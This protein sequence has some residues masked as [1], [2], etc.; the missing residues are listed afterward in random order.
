M[1]EEI[2][3]SNKYKFGL[4]TYKTM[5]YCLKYRENA[6]SKNPE[7]GRTENRRIMFLSKSAVSDSKKLKFIEGQEASGLLSSLGIKAPLN[8]FSLL[9][10][11][12]F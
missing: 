7:V 2:K 5:S 6:E 12:L 4:H 11:L 1:K 9:G 10:P 8:K 3:N